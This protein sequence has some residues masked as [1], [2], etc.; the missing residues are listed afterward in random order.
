MSLVLIIAL[1]IFIT[2]TPLFLKNPNNL[3]IGITLDLLLTVRSLRLV[4]HL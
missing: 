4:Q 3:A 2:K 1:M